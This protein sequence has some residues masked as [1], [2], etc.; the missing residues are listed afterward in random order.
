MVIFLIPSPVNEQ[1]IGIFDS[2]VGGLTVANAI[3]QILPG[4]SLVYFG[5]TA[6]LPYGDKSA[7][8]IRYYSGKITEFLLGHNA[9]VILVA[10]NSASASAF[11]SL[12]EEFSD[13]V[14][15]IDV[16][17]PVVDYL[18][19]KNFRKIGVIGT[20]RTISSGA[21]DSKIRERIPGTQLVSMATPMLVP[22]IEE[23]FIFDDISN[24]IIRTYLSNEALKDIE[25]LI[26][27]CTHYPI[28]RNQISR[29]FN[30]NIE[31]VDSARIVSMI[32]R[33]TLEK[34]NLINDSGNVRD[35]FF[36]SDYTPYFEKIAKMF[37]EG[38]INLRKADIWN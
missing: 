38:E 20:K 19:S 36:I 16:I 22:M 21:Y 11:D 17:D 23:G 29:F 27:G 28:I 15:L 31:V 8:A 13:R 9:K 2:G 37:F 18:S 33:D 26:L 34:N 35:E 4:E 10:C 25:A 12:R 30:F 3:K 14:H 5:D 6:H 1:P 32:L 24:A 7:E